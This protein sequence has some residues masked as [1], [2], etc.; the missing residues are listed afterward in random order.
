MDFI[1]LIAL[2]LFGT[3]FVASAAQAKALNVNGKPSANPVQTWLVS[4][5]CPGV[6]LWSHII[7][8][9]AIVVGVGLMFNEK[10]IG[11][12]WAL[13]F[14]GLWIVLFAYFVQKNASLAKKTT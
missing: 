1:I 3:V 8:G 13:G 6:Y 7:F 10:S 4:I 9:W 2:L 12:W 14:A 5:F 11:P